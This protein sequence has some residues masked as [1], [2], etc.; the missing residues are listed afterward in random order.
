MVE[1]SV[2]SFLMVEVSVVSFFYGG[3]VCCFFFN[4]GGE[5]CFFYGGGECFSTCHHVPSGHCIE[6]YPPLSTA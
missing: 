5:C 6:T 2:V 1:V 3:G 4:G